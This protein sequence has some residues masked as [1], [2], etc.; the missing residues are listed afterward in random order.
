MLMKE[1]LTLFYENNPKIM[2]KNILKK[3]LKK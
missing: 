3:I 1:L 2:A